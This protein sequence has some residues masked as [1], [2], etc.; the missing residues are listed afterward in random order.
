MHPS[1]QMF[2]SEGVKTN[3]AT[4]FQMRCL[5][6]L[7]FYTWCSVLQEKSPTD[8]TSILSSTMLSRPDMSTIMYL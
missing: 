7:V 8:P 3:L 1:V 6:T 2:H 4:G 5:V